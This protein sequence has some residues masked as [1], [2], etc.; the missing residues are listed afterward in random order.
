MWNKPAYYTQ[1]YVIKADYSA[2][3]YAINNLVH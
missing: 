2:G 3:I 1:N